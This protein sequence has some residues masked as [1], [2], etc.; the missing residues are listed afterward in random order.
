[1]EMEKL[2]GEN[3]EQVVPFFKENIENFE[4]EKSTVATS[5][6]EKLIVVTGNQA[7]VL[8]SQELADSE[9]ADPIEPSQLMSQDCKLAV[10]LVY[11]KMIFNK[12]KIM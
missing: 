2:H 7:A 1:M 6:L 4:A 11:V 8:E 9:N 5:S 3:T 12:F 10:H